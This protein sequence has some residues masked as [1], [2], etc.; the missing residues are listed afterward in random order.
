MRH[1]RHRHAE[2]GTFSRPIVDALPKWLELQIPLVSVRST[3]AEAI[4]YALSRWHGMTRFLHCGRIELDPT[5]S[6]ARSVLLLLAGKTAC[7]RTAR[8]A[9][10]A[11]QSSAR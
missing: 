7:S 3:L 2:R 10:I 4:R 9:G 5:L 11:G 1:R 8:A 6:S